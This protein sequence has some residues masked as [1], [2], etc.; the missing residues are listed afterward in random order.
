MKQLSKEELRGIQMD[1][2]DTIHDFCVSNNIK[3]SIEGGTLLGAVRHRGY[4]PWDDDI[5]IYMLREDYQKFEEL[6]PQTYRDHYKLK[7]IYRDKNWHANFSKVYD[8]RT[9]SFL[10]S[11]SVSEYGVDIDVIPVDSVP[12]N[13]HK[14]LNFMKYINFILSIIAN[15]SRKIS[16]SRTFLTNIAI[17]FLSILLL[18][19]SRHNLRMMLEKLIQRHNNKGYLSVYEVCYGLT[20]NNP[21]PRTLFDELILWDFEDRK[22]MGFKDADTYLKLSF[23]DYLTLPPEEKRVSHAEVAYWKE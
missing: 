6:F 7:S 12:D 8:T 5:D 15:K 10:E 18:P 17:V 11:R 1:I 21:F 2:M 13:R 3:Y 19:F 20:L 9:I 14:W 22:Y 16:R 4:I 23:G